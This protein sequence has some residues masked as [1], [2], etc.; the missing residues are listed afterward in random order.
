LRI[1]FVVG[2]MQGTRTVFRLAERMAGDGQRGVLLFTGDACRH[3]ADPELMWTLR[4]AEGIYALDD[5]CR[6]RGLLADLAKP[7]EV[8]DH[9]GWVRLLERCDRVVSWT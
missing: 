3:A 1:L 7:V 9:D 4:F 6:S 8:I 2:R 5:D